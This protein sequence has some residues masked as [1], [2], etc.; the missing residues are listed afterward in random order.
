MGRWGG[1]L[2]VTGYKGLWVVGCGLWVV[3]C[4]FRAGNDATGGRRAPTPSPCTRGEMLAACLLP[5]PVRGERVGVRGLEARG[6]APFAGPPRPNR[7]QDAATT[8]AA[9]ATARRAVNGPSEPAKPA[10]AGSPIPSAPRRAFE[11]STLGRPAAGLSRGWGPR[12]AHPPHAAATRRRAARR[13]V[14]GPSEPPSPPRRAHPVG[15]CPQR[16]LAR[17]RAQ[18]SGPPSRR[19]WPRMARHARRHRAARRAVNGPSGP[20]K[21]A[22]A[23]SRPL[24]A[25]RRACAPGN[26]PGG[27]RVAY[28]GCRARP[29][30]PTSRAEQRS[31]PTPS[32]AIP[33]P[34]LRPQRALARFRAQYSGPSSRRL[35]PRMAYRGWRTADGG[36]GWESRTR[37]LSGRTLFGPYTPTRHPSPRP[38]NRP[39][40]PQGLPSIV[41]RGL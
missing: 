21:P 23:G 22:E 28:R 37:P 35:E 5:L 12:A 16:A 1:R 24:T 33:P 17:F 30:L 29:H 40:A 36:R 7:G 10:E 39:P 38:R 41:A 13:A 15:A 14:N 32:R 34:P 27:P 25:P 9:H 19:P 11:P 6:S 20:T 18:H 3:G 8:D 26:R 2:Q 31:A 4:G